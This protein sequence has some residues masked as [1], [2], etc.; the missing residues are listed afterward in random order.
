MLSMIATPFVLL[1]SLASSLLFWLS[2]RPTERI[3]AECYG[4][5]DC[6]LVAHWHLGSCLLPSHVTPITWRSMYKVN[7]RLGWLSWLL[8]GSSCGAWFL[9][10]ARSSLWGTFAPVAHMT[11]AWTLLTVSSSV[12][13]SKTL[14]LMA[15]CGGRFK[16]NH[17]QDILFLMAWFVSYVIHSMALSKLL[18]PGLSSF[19]LF[20]ALS[21]HISPRGRTLLLYIVQVWWF[22][23][24]CFCKALPQC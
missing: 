2:P 24:H 21:I 17:L 10:E 5:G 22:L 16:C 20:T 7:T 18:G 1:I 8:Q 4:W 13:M 9:A 12:W 3:L 15:T 23:I 14:F 6:C 19:P 11:T